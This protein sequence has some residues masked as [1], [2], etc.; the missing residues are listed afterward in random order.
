MFYI[1]GWAIW[2]ITTLLAI[3]WAFGIRTYAKQ[4]KPFPITTAVQGFFLWL[5]AVVFLYASYSKLHILWI[6]PIC[7]LASFFLTL[8]RRVPIVTPVVLWF[9]GLFVEI[10]T[11][12]IKRPTPQ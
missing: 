11:L 2:A 12:G 1:L 9:A 10:V 7:F 3:S 6:A 4:R 8:A 5:I